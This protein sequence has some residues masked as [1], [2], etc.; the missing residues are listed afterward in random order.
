MDTKICS[1]CGK[2]YSA[3]REYFPPR[4][5]C[6]DG[7]DSW[8]KVCL[9]TISKEKYKQNYLNIKMRRKKYNKQWNETHVKYKQILNRAWNTKYPLQF[10]EIERRHRHKRR[11]LGSEVYIEN[12]IDEPTVEHHI[13]N[14]KVIHVPIDLH[15]L[16]GGT[17]ERHRFMVNQIVEQIY[18][19]KIKEKR[20]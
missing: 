15:I 4:K 7:L 16:Y 10:K 1:H 20:K 13:N 12:I 3:T 6:K 9:N 11:K 5:T 8:C 19:I 14:T 18:G 17:Q 2:E